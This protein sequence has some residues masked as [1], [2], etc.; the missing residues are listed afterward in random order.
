MTISFGLGLF[1]WAFILQLQN[2]GIQYY[3]Q[4]LF[5]DI[6]ECE[7]QC[8]DVAFKNQNNQWKICEW[9][10]KS[11]FWPV[12][13]CIPFDIWWF[14]FLSLCYIINEFFRLC[15]QCD[16][17]KWAFV[18]WPLIL[19]LSTWSTYSKQVW[20]THIS[21]CTFHTQVRNW[22]CFVTLWADS[23]IYSSY[24]SMFSSIYSD[25]SEAISSWIGSFHTFRTQVYNLHICVLILCVT[26]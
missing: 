19:Y 9:W 15:I 6:T 13:R 25:V 22:V 4:L 10:L 7:E 12:K 8:F 24:L 16:C 1:W 5:P 21:F 11:A 3:Y 23:M 26:V 20:L 2:L 17:V 18:L 14:S